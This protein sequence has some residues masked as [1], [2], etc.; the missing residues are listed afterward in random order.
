MK[1]HSQLRWQFDL[2]LFEVEPA[3]AS[4]DTIELFAIRYKVTINCIA[5]LKRKTEEKLQIINAAKLSYSMCT[6]HS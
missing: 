1:N 5:P 3:E 6:M 2:I 4:L